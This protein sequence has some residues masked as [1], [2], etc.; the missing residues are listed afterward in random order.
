MKLT[1]SAA[2]TP[3]SRP[4]LRRRLLALLPKVGLTVVDAGPGTVVLTRRRQL[5][6]QPLD[7]DTAVLSRRRGLT[8][9]RL[10][11]PAATVLTREGGLDVVEVSPGT[12]LVTSRRTARSAWQ[13][14]EKGLYHHLVPAHIAGLLQLYRVNCV[15]DVGANRGQYARML[16]SAGYRGH[17]VSF[18]PVPD[19]FAKLQRAAEKDPAWTVHQVALAAAD[20][21]T[22]MQVVSGT[23][24]SVLPPTE[25]GAG[26]YA[27][28]R[29]ATEVEVPMRRLD[30]LLADATG[31][32]PDCRLYLKMDTQGFDLQA[33]AG[34]G[35]RVRDVVGM[36]SEVAL[37]TI[38]QGMPRLPE[39]L[40]VYEAAGF[41]VTG[42]YPVSR[43]RR[44]ARVLEFDCVMV[45][46]DAR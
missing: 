46:A 13:D 32:V 17:I 27:Q 20:G 36:Q 22:S 5:T 6:V 33:F 19:T 35:D 26:R 24:S 3:V 42:L 28:L 30:G 37:M 23:M 40:E 39:A 25:F 31:H 2:A 43:E 45:R 38:Y 21:V 8:W 11:S 16:R 9:R 41:E 1:G 44:T 7:A 34:L 18:E 12:A 29:D 14:Q 10:D 15:L 4:T